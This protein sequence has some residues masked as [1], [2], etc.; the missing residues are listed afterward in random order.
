MRPVK[1]KLLA[2]ARLLA[3]IRWFFDQ[4]KVMEVCTPVLSQ[5]AGTDPSIAPLRTRYTGPGYPH[6]RDLYLQTSPEFPMKRLL[7]AGS[8]PIYQIAQVFRDGEYGSRHNP[9]FSLLEWYRPG[10]DHHQLMEEVAELMNHCLEQKLT[11]EKIAY[12]DLFRERLGWDPLEAPLSVM[13]ATAR[14]HDLAADGV[15][16][17]DQ[18]LDLFM[19]LLIEPKLGKDGLTFIYDYPASQA[20]LA[21]INPDNPALASRFELYY[22]GVELAN[23][24]HELTCAAEQR[25]RFEQENLRRQRQGLAT[26][27]LD[28]NFL[29]ALES[30]LPD[31]A[32][33]ALGLDRLLMLKLN[34]SC[35]DDVLSFSLKN[36]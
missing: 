19:S 13:Q 9:E 29:A 26:V 24:F 6:G 21:R 34:A 22:R 3:R 35:L 5:A 36:A 15:S 8:G 25:T 7:A 30:G 4:R 28:E 23:G 1:E 12:V 32:G 33:V 17:R 16:S 11:V 14:Q 18:W 31:C 20:S 10:F 27:P 2:R